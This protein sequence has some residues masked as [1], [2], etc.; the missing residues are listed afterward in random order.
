VPAANDSAG[1]ATATAATSLMMR[2]STFLT[3]IL[4]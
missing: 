4:T 1:A 3:S 2:F